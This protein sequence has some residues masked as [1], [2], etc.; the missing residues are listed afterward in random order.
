MDYFRF[1]EFRQVKKDRTF[2]L[3]G[4]VFEAPVDLIDQRIELRFHL[5]SPDD[6]EIFLEGKSFGKACLLDRQVNFRIGRNH[7]LT[8]ETKEPEIKPPEL[9]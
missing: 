3:N 8:S 5:E 4:T 6:V 7:R 9:F 2:R 1:I